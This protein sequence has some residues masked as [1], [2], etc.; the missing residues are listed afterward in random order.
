MF[1]SL[2]SV[3]STVFVLAL[4]YLAS[5]APVQPTELIVWNPM[6]TSPQF[7]DVWVAGCTQN[8]TWLTDNIPDEKK[9]ATG[10]LLLGYYAN[11]SENLDIK[12]PLA[13]GFPIAWGYVQITV[14]ANLT[15]GDNYT[16]VL[17]GDSG[18]ASPAFTIEPNATQCSK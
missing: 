10:L 14:P 13:S 3:F 12:H 17:F 4:S 18:N 6:I 15:R 16:V 2:F 11:N 7:G 9:N 1:S 5:A 8:V